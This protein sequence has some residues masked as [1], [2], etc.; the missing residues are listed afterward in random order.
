MYSRDD[1]EQVETKDMDG[2]ALGS[3]VERLV[4]LDGW[5]EGANYRVEAIQI[6]KTR[7]DYR[8]ARRKMIVRILQERLD[9]PMC[10]G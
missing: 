5:A 3:A 7:S 6:R 9:M 8:S 2:H 10:D 1:V 4:P